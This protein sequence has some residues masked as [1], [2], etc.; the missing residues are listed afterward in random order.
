MSTKLHGITTQNAVILIVKAVMIPTHT[1]GTQ[2]CK[3]FWRL[4]YV[5]IG[6]DLHKDISNTLILSPKASS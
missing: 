4:Q 6:D 1:S 2:L 3:H 5:K